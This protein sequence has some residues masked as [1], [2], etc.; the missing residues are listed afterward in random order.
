MRFSWQTGYSGGG[1][2]SRGLAAEQ[3]ADLPV[4]GHHDGHRQQV[5]GDHP[6]D[7]VGRRAAAAA[8]TGPVRVRPRDG[9]LLR[10]LSSPWSR[11]L[12]GRGDAGRQ[13]R[14]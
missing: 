4:D 14:A 10:A 1:A 6:A 12:T 2:D 13:G 7:V 11:P 9:A 3:V 5:G 8:G